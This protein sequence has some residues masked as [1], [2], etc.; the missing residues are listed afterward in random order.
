MKSEIGAIHLLDEQ[1]TT[2]RLATSCGIPASIVPGID[3]VEVASGLVDGPIDG[4]EPSAVSDITESLQPL[5]AI[6]G[7]DEAAATVVAPVRSRGKSLGV[8]SVVGRPGRVFDDGDVAL[9]ASIADQIG[10]V[11]ENARLYRQAEQLAVVRERERLAR[12]LHD[13]VTQSLYS[14]TLLAE[15]SQ[16]LIGAGDWGRVSEYVGRLGEIAQQALK[17]MRLLVY[18]LRPLV[19][20]REGLVGALQHRLD[21]VEKRAGVDA[22]LLVG[23][24][25]ELPASAEEEL[26]R[27]AQEALNNALKHAAPTSVTVRICADENG[28]V[29]EVSDDGRGFDLGSISAEGG[30]GL[31]SMRE[32]TERLGGTLDVKSVP[33]EGTSVRVKLEVAE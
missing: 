12:E 6:P 31:I 17:E 4:S 15:A 24:I 25:I 30:M 7:V 9:L 2:L 10:V 27:I 11:V 13:S 19:L 32:R 8:L 26:Y 23:G 20:K 18:Q 1:E 22:R 21:A 14:L 29:L 3:S 33:G 16:R 28:V 5:L